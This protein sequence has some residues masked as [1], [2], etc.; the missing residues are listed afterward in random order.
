MAGAPAGLSNGLSNGLSIRLSIRLSNGV[1]ARLC[2]FAS[3]E[4]VSVGTVAHETKRR[5]AQAVCIVQEHLGLPDHA[6]AHA[7]RQ[8]ALPTPALGDSVGI[9]RRTVINASDASVRAASIR[10]GTK[11]RVGTSISTRISISTL[12]ADAIEAHVHVDATEIDLNSFRRWQLAQPDLE[13]ERP[14]RRNP[15]RFDVETH[16]AAIGKAHLAGLAQQIAT[17][18]Q[19]RPLAE[20]RMQ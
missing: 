15:A 14:H 3:F 1:R 10:V 6:R 9:T 20:R 2:R 19:G 18:I 4:S 5:G 13:L 12:Q 17:G 11:I 16:L 8:H 7:H